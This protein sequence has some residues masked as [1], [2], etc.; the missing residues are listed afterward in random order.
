MNKRTPP[1]KALLAFD[2]VSQ[3]LN[4]TRAADE[5]CV[6]Q[7]AVSQQIKIIE[8][9]LGVQLLKKHGQ[10]FKLTSIGKQ[11]AQKINHAFDEIRQASQ[12]LKAETDRSYIITL[13]MFTT[14]ATRWLI[15]RLRDFKNLY[16]KYEVRIVTPIKNVDF[17]NE[18]I[19]AAI[20]AGEGEWKN[21]TA[22][23]LFRDELTPVCSPK[24]LQRLNTKELDLTPYPLLHVPHYE[25]KLDWPTWLAA[26]NCPPL[27][28][29]QV[30]EYS[31]LDLALH[32]A[33]NGLGI[34][35]AH[36]SFIDNDLNY[37][38]LTPFTP[39]TTPAPYAYYYVYPTGMRSKKL[40]LFGD[41]LQQ[42][43]NT[44]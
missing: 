34:A 25:R 35:I 33:A 29:Y 16:P 13:N 36:K 3:S 1:L 40:E 38:I 30:L 8:D 18:D 21:L 11:Y 6:T 32:A 14:F 10:G 2:V 12:W 28:K 9:Y 43:F 42:Q 24:L 22:T 39:L 41:W 27:E 44:V 23:Y 17:S 4:I 20:Y 37:G 7:S 5:L 31:T 26:A 15:P 19:D